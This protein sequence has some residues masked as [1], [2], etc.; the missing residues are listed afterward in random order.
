MIDKLRA[1]STSINESQGNILNQTGTDFEGGSLLDSDDLD[2]IG[3][4]EGF[5]L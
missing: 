5:I 2:S 1:S 4:E 3:N